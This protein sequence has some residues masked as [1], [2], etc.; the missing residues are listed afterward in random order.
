MEGRTAKEEIF[1]SDF[2]NRKLL[3]LVSTEDRSWNV[4][5][6]LS[7]PEVRKRLK[8]LTNVFKKYVTKESSW[9]GSGAPTTFL[10][11]ACSYLNLCEEQTKA[12]IAS[13][14]G[15]V[16]VKGALDLKIED[17]RVPNA[18][19][20]LLAFYYDERAALLEAV[21]VMVRGQGNETG[22]EEGDDQHE[23]RADDGK[24]VH[25]AVTSIWGS[26]LSTQQLHDVILGHEASPERVNFGGLLD[27]SLIT[28]FVT[29]M[30]GG[31][32]SHVSAPELGQL[33]REGALRYEEQVL[34]EQMLLMEI[35]FY[36]YYTQHQSEWGS[37]EFVK[38]M[39]IINRFHAPRQAARAYLNKNSRC[40]VLA[41][42][43]EAVSVMTLLGCMAL[44]VAFAYDP[45]A[46][47][48]EKKD[49]PKDHLHPLLGPLDPDSPHAEGRKV[50]YNGIDLDDRIHQ[51]HDSS[52]DEILPID[53]NDINEPLPHG[54]ILLA[55]GML[56]WK[57]PEGYN[58]G[59]EMSRTVQRGMAFR[60][61]GYL[62]R[63]LQRLKESGSLPPELWDDES[64]EVLLDEVDVQGG[65]MQSGSSDQDPWDAD[66]PSYRAAANELLHA[67]LHHT[68]LI[69]RG[70]HAANPTGRI[71][72]R[73]TADLI[74]VVYTDNVDLCNTFWEE[75]AAEDILTEVDDPE[76]A[77]VYPVLLEYQRYF[78]FDCSNLCHLAA[79][80]VADRKSAQYLFQTFG[81]PRS[82]N[83]SGVGLRSVRDAGWG[84]DTFLQHLDHAILRDGESFCIIMF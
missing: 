33:V 62:V 29:T 1:E 56:V 11:L 41:L 71:T 34:K 57:K 12:L 39:Q 50:A 37:E 3:S 51:Y 75:V 26:V 60:G 44:D 64:E 7:M 17:G 10:G 21:K 14:E 63:A 47:K 69:T 5:T 15:K 52:E 79:S 77:G 46:D 80:L 81:I 4:A 23:N 31:F 6:V 43:L 45:G 54:T 2:S 35:L 68:P 20:T 19:R 67:F 8:L 42:R 13:L 49:D 84:F 40:F 74:A 55:W 30:E 16:L 65:P 70:S 58:V 59:K 76:P 9:E 78:P 32:A 27:F 72:Q 53:P 73:D 28:P 82:L 48:E 38:L 18:L 24:E 83:D 66:F 61:I 36:V 22:N 25:Q